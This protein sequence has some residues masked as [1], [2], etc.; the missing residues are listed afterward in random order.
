MGAHDGVPG[1]APLS[2]WA[3][4]G[5][6]SRCLRPGCHRRAG[7]VARA[8]RHRRQRGAAGDHRAFRAGA[9]R[10]AVARDLLRAGLRL[11]DA[12]LRQAG[13]PVRPS[14]DL[15]PRPAALG[16][17]LRRLRAWRRTGRSSCGRA[18]ARGL[19]RRWR[20]PARRRSPPR[21]SP[22]SGRAKALAGFS[23]WRCRWLPPIGPLLGGA[24]V[25]A[26]GLARRLLDARADRPGRRLRCP[27]CCRRRKLRRSGRSMRG[28]RCCWRVCMS[29]LLA[30]AGPVAAS[31][32]AGLAGGRIAV[33]GAL[34]R[35]AAL[36]APRRRMCPSRS[37]GRR[38]SPIPLS[39][40]PT[41]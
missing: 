22:T 1:Q 26:L 14:P 28:A 9:R 11:A 18:Q 16:L 40:S 6:S 13:R 20:S 8:A 31:R 37:S 3:A 10:R 23:A 7:R 19:A 34:R 2:R 36:R 39:P 30:V 17:R 12:G 27:A 35:L 38:C 25:A 33:R 21:C 32:R 5:A 41:S 24:L 15:P 4:P 29:A